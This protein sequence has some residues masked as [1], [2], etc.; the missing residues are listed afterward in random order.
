M[1]PKNK[2]SMTQDELTQREID[3]DID[4]TPAI[5]DAFYFLRLMDEDN[6]FDDTSDDSESVEDYEKRLESHYKSGHAAGDRL[7]K[8]PYE[9]RMQA[10]HYGYQMIDNLKKYGV[11]CA[12]WA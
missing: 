1:M 7:T 11:P 4:V 10:I 5:E 2:T 8:L 6:K 3:L 9:E 12:A